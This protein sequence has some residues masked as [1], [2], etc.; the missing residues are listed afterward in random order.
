MDSL[1]GR[2]WVGKGRESKKKGGG[3]GLHQYGMVSW[4]IDG[5]CVDGRSRM[6]IDR[7]QQ[8]DSNWWVGGT[9]RRFDWWRSR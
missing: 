9:M 2:R 1:I 5:S 8:E 4:K 6:G 3:G 7:Q